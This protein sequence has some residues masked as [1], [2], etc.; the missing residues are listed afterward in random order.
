M[1]KPSSKDHWSLSAFNQVVC[2]DILTHR[3]LDTPFMRVRI[4]AESA[5]YVVNIHPSVR[6]HESAKV[7]LD[8]FTSVPSSSA[9]TILPSQFSANPFHSPVPTRSCHANSVPIRSIL[10][11]QHD[12]ATPIQCQSV[13]FSSANTILPCQFSANPFRSPVPSRSLLASSVPIRSIL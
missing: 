5:C 11:C 3:L 4:I 2:I 10:Q 6:P 1:C 7:T 12:L 9:V 8:G 13:P